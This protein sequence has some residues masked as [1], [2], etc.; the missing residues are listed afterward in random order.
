[1]AIN[2]KAW[3][4][5]N[6]ITYAPLLALLP[7]DP[8][9]YIQFAYPNDFTILPII[10]YMEI[11]QPTPGMG[12][13]EDMPEVFDSSVEVHAWTNAPNS[14]TPLMLVLCN[15]FT[16]LLFTTD[17]NADVPEPNPKYQHRVMRFSRRLTALDIA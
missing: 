3:I 12:F 4:V 9:D 15:L 14:T 1:M 6:M 7:G 10:T 8:L 17:Y 13:Y 5:N 16:S 2:A 11:G